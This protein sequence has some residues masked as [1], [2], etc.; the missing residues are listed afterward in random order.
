MEYKLKRRRPVYTL[1][2]TNYTL[3]HRP[4]EVEQ[5]GKGRFCTA[6]RAIADQSIVYLLVAESQGDYS[7]EILSHCSPSPYLPQIE[8]LG[9][10][11]DRRLYQTR[12]YHP[13]KAK[14]R[15][16]WQ[17]F[18]LLQSAA[19][20]ARKE[21]IQHLMQH[22]WMRG[23]E[24]M[25][26]TIELLEDT[27][28]ADLSSTLE[29]LATWAGDYAQSYTF[30]FAARNLA[31]DDDGHLILLDPIFD[32]ETIGKQRIASARRRERRYV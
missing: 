3:E 15:T 23:H 24:C 7:K 16:A 30:E 8:Q 2:P 28:P 5:I 13:L 10:I 21:T 22:W 20:T 26:R 11:G 14:H 18:R 4:V 31:V 27:I 17:Q 6:Y 29:H 25:Q 12:Y 1:L 9:E 19:E 32:M